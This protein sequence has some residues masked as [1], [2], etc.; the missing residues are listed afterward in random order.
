MQF[1][2]NGYFQISYYQKREFYLAYVCAFVRASM[3]VGVFWTGNYCD[4]ITG[5]GIENEYVHVL[6]KKYDLHP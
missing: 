6:A 3:C 1:E 5:H 2:T 4:L